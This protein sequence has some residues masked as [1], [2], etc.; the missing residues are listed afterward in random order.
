MKKKIIAL[1]LALAMC[2]S[3]CACGGKSET[4]P[5]DTAQNNQET[6]EEP[7]IQDADNCTSLDQEIDLGFAKML[8]SSAE[9]TYSVGGDGFFSTAH[10]GMRFFS[11]AGTLEN[12]GGSD[13]PVSNINAEMIFNGEYT[14]PAKATVI[15]SKKVPVSVSPL[16]KAEYWIYAEIP[17]TL[18]DMLSTCEVRFSLNN[19]FASYPESAEKGD[20]AYKIK[21]DEEICKSALDGSKT[22]S[23]FFEECPILPTP[24]N[25]APVRKTTS[26]SSSHNGKVSSIKYG[27]SVMLGRNDS[28]NDIMD[29]YITELENA[30][31]EVQNNS[32]SACDIYSNGIKLASVSL[33]GNNMQFDI[34]PGNENV[35][36]PS[37]N[38]ASQTPAE[39][40]AEKVFKIGDTIETDYAV[41]TL[42]ECGS[43]SEIRSGSSQ[44]G[45]YR[46]YSSENGDPYFYIYG[47]FKNIGGVPVDI[48]NVYVQFCFDEK[49]NYKGDTD[50]VSSESSDFINDV[51]PL[52]TVNCYIYTAVPQE[53]IDSYEKCEVRIG[54]TED[55]DYKVIDVNDLPKFENCDDIFTVE[56][57]S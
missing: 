7:E 13:L 37:A 51:S 30:G 36:A 47:T 8:F 24:T 5:A 16:V 34:V 45:T 33:S 23:E 22:A 57:A 26:S 12:T 49:Y 27:F 50:G 56:I 31:F 20:Y 38:N 18:L 11:I 14:Y 42:D 29:T 1:L 21:L 39:P 2:F 48:R 3:L 25:Y 52:S 32:G 40:M 53:L 6:K 44:Y 43:N 10:D 9:L 35:P 15:N 55:F 28:L 46:Y 19:N 4:A 17:E 54:F 41:L